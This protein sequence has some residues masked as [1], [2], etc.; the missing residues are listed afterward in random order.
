MAHGGRGRSSSRGRKQ[1]RSVSV[2]TIALVV[3]VALVS[4]FSAWLVVRPSPVGDSVQLGKPVSRSSA[5][6]DA[7]RSLLVVGDSWT[8]GGP[9]NS[10]PTWPTLMN[11]PD[12][13]VVVQDAA[14]GSGYIGDGPNLAMT[15]GGRLGD[16]LRNYSPDVVLVAMG[17]NDVQHDPA[18]VIARATEDIGRMQDRWDDAEIVVFSPFSPTEPDPSTIELTNR[19]RDM[20]GGLGVQFLDVSRLI[21][22]R[23]A[24]IK[25]YHPNDAGQRAIA[26]EVGKSLAAMGLLS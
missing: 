15:S 2:S 21:G 7:E 1:K 24:L 6:P 10:G 4:A 9:M 25:D 17:R 14:G 8:E 23:A 26:A 20:S 3:L 5:T 16:I 11:V 18:Q 19:L 12:E 13:W 22:L